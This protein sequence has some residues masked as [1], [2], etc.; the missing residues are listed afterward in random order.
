VR[1]GLR[2]AN[3]PRILNTVQVID[4]TL[5]TETAT[6]PVWHRYTQDGYGEHADGSPFDGT[7]VGRGWPLLAGERAH[8]ELALGHGGEARRLARVMAAQSSPGGLLPEQVWDMPDVPERE[9]FNGRPSGS[10]MPLV[11]AHAEYIKLLRSLRDGQVFDTPP[12][13]VLR[14]QVNRRTSSLAMWRLNHKCRAFPAGKRLRIELLEPA[15]LHWSVDDWHTVH[16]TTTQDTGLGMHIADLPTACLR[17]G[18]RVLFTV[19]WPTARRWE[20]V[21]YEVTVDEPV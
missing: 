17:P 15:L 14:Y 11:W 3:D 6:G 20:G 13:P 16:D 7:G 8:Y 5:K 4:A 19:F 21:D 18:D 10:A 9:L 12:Q 1:F 2:A